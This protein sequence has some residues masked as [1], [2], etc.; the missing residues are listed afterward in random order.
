MNPVGRYAALFIDFENIFYFL[1]AALGA[2]D[3]PADHV[4]NMVREIKRFLADDRNEQCIVMHAYADFERLDTSPQGP[5]YLAGVETHNVLGTEHK[6]AADMKLCI[7][8]LETM[9]TRREI[10]TFVLVAGDRDYIPVIQHLKK[11]AKNVLAVGFLGN[12]SGDLLQ[13]V[14][15][16]SFFDAA[17]FVSESVRAQIRRHEQRRAEE[18][19][20]RSTVRPTG[21]QTSSA[22]VPRPTTSQFAAVSPLKDENEIEALDILLRDFGH[23]PEVWVSPYLNTLRREFSNL[24]EFERKDLIASLATAGA[25]KVEQRPGEPYPY[26]VLVINWNHPD[27]RDRNPG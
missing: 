12:M 4:V 9:Y 25:V 15:E 17:L 7:D 14:G 16:E 13:N 2:Q 22:T 19:K 27:V 23:H 11:H 21:R 24:A 5:L 3:E 26:S 18:I 1:K 20:A 8:A 10:E 6:N